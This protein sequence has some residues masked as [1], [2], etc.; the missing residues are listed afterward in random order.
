MAVEACVRDLVITAKHHD[1][2]A[3]YHSKT[4]KFNIVDTTPLIRVTR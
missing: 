2:F 1:G 3:M 4:S